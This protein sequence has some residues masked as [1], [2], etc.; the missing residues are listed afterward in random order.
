[1]YNIAALLLNFTSRIIPSDK[2]SPASS[3][4]RFLSGLVGGWWLL[5]PCPVKHR[6]EEGG[7]EYEAVQRHKLLTG[8]EKQG[9]RAAIDNGAR[10]GV[11]VDG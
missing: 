10:E 8:S 9:L 7:E 2:H 1:M 4:N 11:W 6:I 5:L 3:F